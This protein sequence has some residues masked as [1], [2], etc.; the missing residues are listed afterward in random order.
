M[1]GLYSR[2]FISLILILLGNK[3]IIEQEYNYWIERILYVAVFIIGI[4]III[5]F[6]INKIPE[7]PKKNINLK[8]IFLGFFTTASLYVFGQSFVTLKSELFDLEIQSK[9]TIEFHFLLT[10]ILWSFLEELYTRRIIAQTVSQKYSLI[11][12]IFVSSF[13]FSLI[14]FFTDSGLFYTFLG[15]IIFSML[16][17]RT[18]SFILVIV[19][20]LFHN[21]LVTFNSDYF[22]I[23]MLQME[24]KTILLIVIASIFCYIFSIIIINK[25]Y[26]YTSS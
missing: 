2:I 3:F 15:G 23:K 21:L 19:L 12:G 16:Y 11:M 20:H 4:G 9:G 1:K 18:G 10:L 17:L 22:I 8:I 26:K 14:H 13:I 7:K 25:N 6:Q 24:I 5:D